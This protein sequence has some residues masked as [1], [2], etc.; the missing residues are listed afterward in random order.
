MRYSAILMAF[1]F[2]LAAATIMIPEGVQASEHSDFVNW[3]LDQGK[4]FDKSWIRM[5]GGKAAA[6]SRSSIT[7]ARPAALRARSASGKALRSNGASK[8]LSTHFTQRGTPPLL[9]MSTNPRSSPTR[10]VGRMTNP[11]S[12]SRGAPY[13]RKRP[14]SS[15]SQIRSSI[16][17][18]KDFS[19][20]RIKS[21][22]RISSGGRR[23]GISRPYRGSY[24][25]GRR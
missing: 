16:G 3:A 2:L 1:P 15:S 6:V 21:F 10:G 9:K 20:P 4:T 18:R 13:N 8:P 7:S 23:G 17:K 14:Y 19:R 24:R 22:G 5:T 25:R 12:I 11:S